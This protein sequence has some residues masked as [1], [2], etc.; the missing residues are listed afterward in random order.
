[1]R[2]DCLGQLLLLSPS[3]GLGTGFGI[4]DIIPPAKATRVIPDEAL[5][6]HIVV[7][8]PGPEGKEVMQAPGELV[9][10]MSVDGLKQAQD[11]ED[12]HGKDVQV[13]GDG[14]P[15]DGHAQRSHC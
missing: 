1:M 5:V 9:S 6:M 14:T 8:G 13:V 10:A 15:E 4:E 7:I 11:D 3:G 12:V 2:L